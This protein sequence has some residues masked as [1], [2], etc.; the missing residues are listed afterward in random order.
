MPFSPDS[1]LGDVLDSD[2]GRA[3]VLGYLPMVSELPFPVQA[4]HATI[5]QLVDLTDMVR[6]DPALRRDLFRELAA[7]PDSP[8]PVTEI[9]TEAPASPLYEDE[10]AAAAA[11]TAPPSAGRWSV[12]E[13]EIRGPSHGNPYVDVELWAQFAQGRRRVRVPGFYDGDGVYRIRF[14]PDAEGEWTFLTTS[15]ARSLAGLAGEFTCTPAGAGGHGPVGVHET[16][17]FRH[18][19]GTRCL[20]LGTTAYAWTHQGD[21]LEEQTLRTLA[22]SPFT[23]LRMCVF[24]KSYDYNANEPE[25]YPFEGSLETG[26]DFARPNPGFWRHL[27]RRIGQLGALGIE[28][29]LILFHAYD[30]WG[31]SD[32]GPAADDRYVRYA[33]ARLAALQNV[34]WALANEY[35][36]LWSKDAADWDRFAGLIAEHDPYGHL[37]SNHNCRAFFDNSRPWV[38]HASLQRVDVYKTAENATEWRRA[39]GKP[40][41]IDECA[42]E[43]D[44]DQGW[45]NITA[46]E[47][48]R[49]FWEGAVR[50]AYVGHGETYLADDE[51]LWWSKGGVLKGDSPARIGFL[52]EIL[53]QGPEGLE[54]LPSEWDLPWAGIAGEYYLA[55]FGFSR[56][57]FRTF[58]L[59]PGT[60]YAVDVIDTWNMTVE[61]VEGSFEGRFRIDLPG[62]Q[63]M[64]V[65]LTA[66]PARAPGSSRRQDAGR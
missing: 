22:Q 21:E 49:R 7:V 32:M 65:R 41:V 50:G 5:R 51:V 66:S 25:H 44:I 58:A 29:D 6:D 39:W 11:L 26:W 20:P 55:Y 28:A 24:P 52:R 16:F 14:M 46:E 31:F 47:M 35:D 45:G 60:A 30:R 64:A 17:H 18:A 4:R 40:V 36:L 12:Y 53:E 62:R 59:P 9:A 37:L 42:Y 38:T 19:D 54:P 10:G 2:A 61:P 13:L 63:Y 3:V 43:G 1:R 23:K 48:V 15:N 56:P 57:R 33:V 27:E 8:P 34:W